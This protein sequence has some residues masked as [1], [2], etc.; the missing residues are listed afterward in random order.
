MV[1]GNKMEM[2]MERVKRIIKEKA[3]IKRNKKEKT[4]IQIQMM[5]R[6]LK[7]TLKN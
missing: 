3:R 5:N 4:Q 2:Q 1:M 6:T 7:R